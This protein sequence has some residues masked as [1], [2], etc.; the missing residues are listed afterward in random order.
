MMIG[1]AVRFIKAVRTKELKIM[2]FSSEEI[3]AFAMAKGYV[4]TEE[5]LVQA[6]KRLY[7]LFNQKTRR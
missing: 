5:E 1:D 4:F 3:I 6:H 7:F 2:E